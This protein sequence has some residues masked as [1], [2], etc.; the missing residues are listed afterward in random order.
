MYTYQKNTNAII[1]KK[2]FFEFNYSDRSPID[3]ADPDFMYLSKD[4]LIFKSKLDDDIDRSIFDTL[5]DRRTYNFMTQHALEIVKSICDKEEIRDTNVKLNFIFSFNWKRDF[6]NLIMYAYSYL[7]LCLY[8]P[9]YML[10]DYK[11]FKMTIMEILDYR[12]LSD[13]K[14]LINDKQKNNIKLSNVTPYL[15]IHSKKNYTESFIL[16]YKIKA[17]HKNF[18]KMYKDLLNILT[19]KYQ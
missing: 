18:F 1:S 16:N 11:I 13:A 7:E 10:E 12:M 2:N 15:L 17:D 14:L 9:D 19:D 8:G 4:K 6:L 5:K 3:Y